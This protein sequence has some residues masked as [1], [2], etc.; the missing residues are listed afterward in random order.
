MTDKYVLFGNPV[1]HS[2][3][4]MLHEYFAKTLSQDLTYGRI[5]VEDGCFKEAALKFFNEDNGLGCNITVPCKLDAYSFA[6][7][8]SEYAKAAGAV[9]TLKKLPDGKIYG[10]NTDG[11][12]LVADLHRLNCPL[13]GNKVL[14]IGAG[15]AAKGIL[16]P[17][18]ETNPLSITI[19][20]RTES[21]A[22]DLASIYDERVTG[23]SFA[24]L[25]GQFDVIINATSSSLKDE[26]PALNDEILAKALFVYDLMYRKGGQT[27]FTKK[28]N[29]LGVKNAF[30]GFGMLIGQ[31][32][33]SFEVWRGVRPDFSLA[34][35]KFI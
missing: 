6:D 16:K 30:D 8:L 23:T 21:K 14:I 35:E 24:N 13:E 32:I 5:L 2:M 15:G 9:N 26:L 19:V 34:V 29:E 11:R 3:S 20:N 22:L 10:D 7:V 18:L 25:K 31:A 4:P 28:A 27:V 33:L 17:I 12:G 1:E